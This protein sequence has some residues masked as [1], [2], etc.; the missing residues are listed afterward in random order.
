MKIRF[1]TPAGVLRVT[2]DDSPT[3][4]D[5]WRMLP[6]K[7]T[8][9]DYAKTEK[10]STLSRQLSTERAPEGR[11]PRAGDFSYYAPWGNVALFYRDFGYSPGLIFLGKRPSNATEYKNCFTHFD[12]SGATA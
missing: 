3:A 4:R 6:L 10:V 2:L 9:D 5:F 7:M 1:T 11:E 12:S 8:L